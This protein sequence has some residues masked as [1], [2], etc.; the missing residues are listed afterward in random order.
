ML[1]ESVAAVASLKKRIYLSSPHMSGHELTLVKEAFDSNWIAPL[2]PHVDAFEQELAEYLGVA[3]ALA[4]NSGTAAIHLAL[5][6]VGV[7]PGDDVF[8]SSLTF[9][10]SANPI[11]YLGA[12]PAF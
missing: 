10:A 12:K 8:C 4:V 2:G 7:G 5:R 3:G 1:P 6:L 11:L 9:V